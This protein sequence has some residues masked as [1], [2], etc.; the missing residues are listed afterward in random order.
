M[1]G[2]SESFLNMAWS[3]HIKS[4]EDI[5]PQLRFTSQAALDLP[6]TALSSYDSNGNVTFKHLVDAFLKGSGIPCPG[7]FTEALN[8]FNSSMLDLSP[9]RVEE[10]SF[11]PRI[12]CWAATG[13]PSIEING[14]GISVS[15]TTS[16]SK[17]LASQFLLQISLCGSSDSDHSIPSRREVMMREGTICFQTCTKQVKVPLP[18]LEKL[19]DATYAAETEPASFQAAFDHWFLCELLNAIGN[20]SIL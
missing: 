5:E 8:H 15:T 4:F 16:A 14:P 18:Y 11:R 9:V 10:P 7:L 6:T 13:S 19:A 17:S 2:G 20:H 1:E 3:S 12:F